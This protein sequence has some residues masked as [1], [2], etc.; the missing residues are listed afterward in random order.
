MATHGLGSPGGPFTR[1]P[2]HPGSAV[3]RPAPF[4]R[5]APRP[6][7]ARDIAAGFAAI[8]PAGP[9]PADGLAAI[10]WRMLGAELHTPLLV[11]VC[12]NASPGV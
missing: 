9:A 5:D 2:C 3:F 6:V 11:W 1:V 10:M 8:V 7:A 4:G 12:V